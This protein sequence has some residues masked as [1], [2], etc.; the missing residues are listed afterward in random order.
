MTHLMELIKQAKIAIEKTQDIDALNLIRIKF[1]GK[2]GCLTLHTLM[3]RNL[4]IKN[5]SKIEIIINQAKLEVQNLLNIR[6]EQ[7]ENILFNN[8][9]ER[10]KIDIS[11]P[12][13][14]SENGSFH[15][16]TNTINRIEEFFNK[17]SF[18]IIYG[19]EIEDDYHN[20]DALN[21][22]INHPARTTNDT[23]WFDTN[24]LLRTQ[25]S[26]VQIRTMKNKKPPIRMIT[27]GRVYRHDYDQT[28]TPMFHQT[29]G[30]VVD[31]NINFATLKGTLHNFLNY[32]FEQKTLIRFRPSYF[33]FTEPS[34]EVDVMNKDGKWLEILGCGMIH[35]NV[36][37]NVNIDPNLYSGFA[38]GIGIERLTMLYY[39]VIDLRNFFENDIRFLKQFI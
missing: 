5:K 33:P 25:T 11:L 6:K 29:E 23:F 2:K 4:M 18:S 19:P 22:P 31:K 26:S 14:Q 12:G 24:R 34:A 10:E 20:F 15:P 1:L 35:P 8:K 27:P 3:L 39:G 13:R 36:L 21:I 17:L 7:L 38:F 28:H 37:F 16:I 9:L 32:F 30:L